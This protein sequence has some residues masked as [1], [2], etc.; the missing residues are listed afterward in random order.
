MFL[1]ILFHV[2]GKL[3][4]YF[5]ELVNFFGLTNAIVIEKVIDPVTFQSIATADYGTQA[6]T[7]FT[8]TAAEPSTQR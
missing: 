7:Y 1:K 5:V 3:G 6:V 4:A 2:D 8:R